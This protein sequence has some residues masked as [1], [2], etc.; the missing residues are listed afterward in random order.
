MPDS[1]CKFLAITKEKALELVH[2][3][4]GHKAAGMES[5]TKFSA[6]VFKECPLHCRGLLL[7]EFEPSLMA[8][9]P[10]FLPLLW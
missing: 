2:H 5:G 6:N 7:K 4:V 3:H 9:G 1:R 8:T 10:S